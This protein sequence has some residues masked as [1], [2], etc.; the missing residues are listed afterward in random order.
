MAAFGWVLCQ[1]FADLTVYLITE[2]T[3]KHS[4]TMLQQ[5]QQEIP[6]NCDS[7][8]GTIL[9]RFEFAKIASM[10]IGKRVQFFQFNL[11]KK[12]TN[13]TALILK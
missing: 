7:V 8:S 5:I 10:D 6:G 12:N 4:S 3:T 9:I 2:M 11:S 13:G 1:L